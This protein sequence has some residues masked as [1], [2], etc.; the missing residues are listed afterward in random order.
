MLDLPS[1]SARLSLLQSIFGQSIV[2]I[3]ELAYLLLLQVNLSHLPVVVS[4]LLVVVVVRRLLFLLQL[5]DW[6]LILLL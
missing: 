6:L 3:L 5:V 2:G 1:R 4:E